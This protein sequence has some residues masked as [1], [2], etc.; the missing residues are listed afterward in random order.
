MAKDRSDE[1]VEKQPQG[2]QQEMRFD[3]LELMKEGIP[4]GDQSKEPTE[5]EQAAMLRDPARYTEAQSKR[6]ADFD[7]AM[8]ALDR[9][10]AGPA[11]RLIKANEKE[12]ELTK[13]VIASISG[14]ADEKAK[15]AFEK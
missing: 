8:Q 9:G 2:D 1:R 6:Q 5:G 4:K 12:I 10:D 15:L 3:A 14:R 11:Q 7:N 13:Q